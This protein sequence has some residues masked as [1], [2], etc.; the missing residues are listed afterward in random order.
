MREGDLVPNSSI[1]TTH[2]TPSP[3]QK[4]QA[5]LARTWLLV[6]A[7]QPDRYSAAVDSPPMLCS[8]TSKTLWH[9]KIKTSPAKMFVT[10]SPR[11]TPVGLTLTATG[12]HGGKKTSPNWPNTLP[13][14][15]MARTTTAA[16]WV[17]CWP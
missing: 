14:N 15:S 1:M 8:M 11:D 4:V 12:A 6:N 7:A 13:T 5:D 2:V 10:G 16:C 17:S 3:G 9:Q